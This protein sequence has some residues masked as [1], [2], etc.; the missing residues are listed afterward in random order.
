MPHTSFV[1]AHAAHPDWRVALDECQRQVQAQ[2]AARAAQPEKSPFTLGWCYLSDYYAPE[3]EAILD[4]LHRAL[5]GVAWVG[6][7]GVGVAA[8][9]IEYIDEPALVLMLA[10][11]PRDSFRLF[12][13]RQPLPA[14]SI[15]FAAY[16]ALV[17]A[18][19]STPDLQELLHELSARTTS[20]YLFGGLSSARNRPLHIADGVFTG[21]LSGVLFGPEVGLISRMTQGCQPIGPARTITRAERNLVVTLDGEPA[22]DCVLKDLG[23]DRDLPFD[24]LSQALSTTLVG[25]SVGAEDVPKGPG[26]F[27]A[28]TLVRHVVG[29][30]PQ[31]RVLA[32]ADRVEPGMHLSFCTRNA[33]AARADLVRIATEI[34]A[35]LK[36]GTAGH[37]SG[38]LY[39]S[40]SGRGGPHFGAPH[41]ELQTVRNAL[42]DVPLVGFFAGGEIARNHLYGYT[43]IL[44]VFTS[45]D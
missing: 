3:S 10:P 44:T 45:R 23:L 19:G 39:V 41:A 6:T 37:L 29:V 36:S 21:G 35:E 32:V 16:T 17:H 26:R 9:G 28:D 2:M 14:T 18:E 25:L 7:V 34:R 40:C 8:S 12:S 38:A 5:P 30:D 4:A 42:G 13:G 11:L 22:L 31:H 24:A 33:E 1:H 27:G 20:G 43:G 15:G